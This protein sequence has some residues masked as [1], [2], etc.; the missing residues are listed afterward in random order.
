MLLLFVGV[1]VV[2]VVVVFVVFVV[3]AVVF[4]CFFCFCVGTPSSQLLKP[5]RELVF[6]F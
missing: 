6:L 2:V 5:G 1:A 3:V 4:V